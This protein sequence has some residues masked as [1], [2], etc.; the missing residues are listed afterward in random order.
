MAE[1]VCRGCGE[2]IR[3]IKLENGKTIVVNEGPVWV[4]LETGGG[5][6][7]SKDGAFVFGT[8]MGDADDDPDA[9]AIG[10]YIPHKG[11]CPTGGRRPRE[12]TR[13]NGRHI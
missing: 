13:R 9:N 4:R 1:E 10:A 11:L 5:T 6:F 8:L 12:R 7:V 3:K 2:P